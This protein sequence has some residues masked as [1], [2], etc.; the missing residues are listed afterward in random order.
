[1]GAFA[2]GREADDMAGMAKS[3]TSTAVRRAAATA[4]LV[5]GFSL[6][7]SA[8]SDSSITPLPN[9]AVAPAPN[10]VREWSGEDGASGHPQMTA[11][12]I[13][14]AAANFEN[15]LE[16]LFPLAAKRGVTRASFNK[17]VKGLTPDLRIMD[18]VDAQPE[19]TKAFWDYLDILVSDARIAGGLEMLARHKA[20]FDAVE[21][22]YGVDRH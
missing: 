20:S 2:D 21:K 13:R 12:A 15:C 4:L 18:F 6:P 11:S 1:M 10:T 14:A 9:A 8:Q 16:G 3:F 17:Y 19:F 5:V 7:A 22:A